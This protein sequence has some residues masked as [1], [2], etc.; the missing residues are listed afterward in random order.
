MTDLKAVYDSLE[1]IPE[2]VEDFRS[3]FVEREGRYELSGLPGVKTAADVERVQRSLVQEREAHKQTKDK[4]RPFAELDPD[5]VFAKLDRLPELEAAAS[6][7]L[8]DAAIDEIVAKRIEGAVRSKLAPVEREFKAAQTELEA[9]REQNQ[10]LSLERAARQRQDAIRPLMA[11]AGVLPEHYEDVELYAERHLEQTEDGQ[12]V[13]KDGVG[14]TPGLQ[15]KEWLA[16]MLEKRPGWMPANV[17]GG[18]KG[19]ASG[20]VGGSNPFSA[21]GWNLTAQGQLVQTRGMEYA[22]RMAEA[23]GTKVGG[24]RPRE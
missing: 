7:K 19:S 16:E 3:L 11:K 2:N 18:A 21:K 23:A 4:F 15:P 24:A 17:G 1:D 20:G 10:A 9:L 5:E 22:Q 14:V 13:A 8:D 12:W 6:G